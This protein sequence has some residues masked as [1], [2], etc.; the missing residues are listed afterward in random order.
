MVMLMVMLH[1]QKRADKF[2]SPYCD[3]ELPQVSAGAT[4]EY[5]IENSSDLADWLKY[6]PLDFLEVVNNDAVDLQLTIDQ[7]AKFYI[8]S[9][10]TRTLSHRSWRRFEIKNLD[11]TTATTVGKVRISCQKMALTQDEALRRRL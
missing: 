11:S 7:Q 10:S 3:I 2:G 6:A 8:P 1:R 5:E 4:K 9:G